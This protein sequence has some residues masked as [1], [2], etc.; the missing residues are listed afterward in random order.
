[1]LHTVDYILIVLY[2]AV[3]L[4]LGL[5]RRLGRDSTVSDLIVGGRMLTLPAFVASLVSTWYGGILAVGEYTFRYGIS[6]W[7]VLGVPYYVAAFLFAMLL[8]RRARE[9]QVL[10]IPQRLAQTYGDRTAVVGSVVIFI[11]TVPAAYVLMLGTVC[12]YLFGWP[13]WIGV[14][15]GTVFSIAY[16]YPVS[17]THLR[18]HET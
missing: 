15:L 7:L 6:N 17:Y 2:L 14:T 5:A 12:Q 18:A 11:M 8:A 3:L 13:F 4:T 1:M 16:I 9:S 10:T